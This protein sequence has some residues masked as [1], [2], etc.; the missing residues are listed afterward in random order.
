VFYPDGKEAT[1]K[2]YIKKLNEEEIE[3]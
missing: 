2:I 1:P 3:I